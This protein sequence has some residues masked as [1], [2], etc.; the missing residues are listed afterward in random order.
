MHVTLH[1]CGHFAGSV[2]EN[3]TIAKALSRLSEVEEKVES[4]HQEMVRFSV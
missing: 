1:D 2:E 4:L 3:E